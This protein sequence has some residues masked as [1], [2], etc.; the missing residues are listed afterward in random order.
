MVDLTGVPQSLLISFFY[1]KTDN[2]LDRIRKTL[3]IIDDEGRHG[4]LLV[5][6]GAFS[7]KTL[8]KPVTLKD[9]AAWLKHIEQPLGKWLIGSLN[10]D[11]LGDAK[12]SYRN[13]QKLKDVGHDTIPV[14]HL[15]D[16]PSVAEQYAKDGADF[17]ALGAMVG[18]SLPVKTRWAATV[19]RHMRDR[20]PHVRFHG[21][22]VG[23]PKIV[24]VLPFY[25]IDSSSFGAG[26]R[27]GRM[28]LWDTKNK[29]FV[30]VQLDGKNNT[31][32]HGRLLRDVYGSDPTF[33]NKSSAKNTL[34]VLRLAA[35]TAM[36]WQEHLRSKRPVS[37]PPSLQQ[38]GTHGHMVDVNPHN[39][40][41]S[42]PQTGTLIHNV[43]PNNP[44]ENLNIATIK[45]T[46][47]N[48]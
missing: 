47:D 24:D 39:L 2:R 13:W 27:Y 48:R 6:S 37:P 23:S 41:G 14:T 8:G 45:Q 10:L 35:L 25:S 1:Y 18:Q 33:I 19:F 21:L 32:R 46:K 29:K 40:Q 5:D 26:Y 9:Y 12:Q 4:R 43:S 34:E 44:L 30:F 7:A 36:L 17:I 20:Y 38:N 15:H 28:P 22:G 3:Q 16:P 42:T 31:H 11:V